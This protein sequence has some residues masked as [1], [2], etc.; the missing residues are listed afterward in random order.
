MFIVDD[1]YSGHNF[2]APRENFKAIYLFIVDT[3]YFLW[4]NKNKL[5]DK[6]NLYDALLY[7]SITA[8]TLLYLVSHQE[9]HEF[10]ELRASQ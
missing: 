6:I 8:L 7:F 2:L 10:P 3:S 1:C 9:F 4:K 5:F